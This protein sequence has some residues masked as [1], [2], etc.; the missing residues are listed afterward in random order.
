MF[1][2]SHFPTAKTSSH[3]PND[4]TSNSSATDSWLLSLLLHHNCSHNSQSSSSI[5]ASNSTLLL[6]SGSSRNPL[7]TTL[8]VSHALCNPSQ[9]HMPCV[10]QSLTLPHIVLQIPMTLSQ[11]VLYQIQTLL[12]LTM[13]VILSFHCQSLIILHHLLHTLL[14]LN[15]V[16]CLN[17]V[18]LLLHLQLL[19]SHPLTQ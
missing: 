10:I 2:E 9:S 15:P 11:S 17:Q 8:T 7:D 5:T 18:Q 6:S 19:L 3:T 12:S 4:P 13:T 16:L 14:L 1:N